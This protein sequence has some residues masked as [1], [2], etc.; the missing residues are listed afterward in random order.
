MFYMWAIRSGVSC[1]FLLCL[2]VG[3]L[4]ET[5]KQEIERNKELLN[6]RDQELGEIRQQMAKLTKIVDKQK[7]EIK[8]LE[9]QLR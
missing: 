5:Q 7:D 2:F 8:S 4:S 9:I 1:L 3:E 6:H